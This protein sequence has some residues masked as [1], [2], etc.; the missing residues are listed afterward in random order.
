MRLIILVGFSKGLGKAI[1]EQLLK[2]LTPNE[3]EL[4]AVGRNTMI[5]P[6]HRAV[7]YLEAD[8]L[9]D[10]CWESLSKYIPTNVS[11]LDVIINAS[12]IEPIG[13]VGSLNEVQL[14]N[15][16]NV[17]YTSP[18]KLI[19]QLVCYQQKQNFFLNIFNITSGASNKA[20]DG[21]SLY[22]STKAAL[23][24]FLDV[25]FSESQGKM[26]LTHIDPGVIDT[27]M[28]RT[29]RSKSEKEMKN[30]QQFREL[31]K[32]NQL[33]TPHEAARDVLTNLRFN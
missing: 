26:E 25:S 10:N 9:N 15:A 20:I 4:L 1:F 14:D 11:K 5:Q 31:N 6:K 27:D 23:K 30:V 8:L 21:W 22:C 24:M 12:V 29:I 28:Q 17:N 33:K 13:I 19:N 2:S 32:S 3:V 18:M 16:V 7:T